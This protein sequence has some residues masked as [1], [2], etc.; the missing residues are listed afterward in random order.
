MAQKQFSE[1]AGTRLTIQ[2]ALALQHLAQ[3]VGCKQSDVLRFLIRS[4]AQRPE[5]VAQAMQR[6]TERQ[7]EES[8]EP[9]R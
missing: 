7:P 2:E 3:H 5:Q 6:E 8:H 1:Y 9:T 4:A